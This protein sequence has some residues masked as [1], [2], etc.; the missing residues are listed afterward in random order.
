MSLTVIVISSS[1]THLFG[2]V[3]FWPS[4]IDPGPGNFVP[5]TAETSPFNSAPWM[6]LCSGGHWRLWTKFVSPLNAVNWSTSSCVTRRCTST[7]A[8]ELLQYRWCIVYHPRR[9]NWRIDLDRSIF[10][11]SICCSGSEIQGYEIPQ[12]FICGVAE[13]FDDFHVLLLENWWCRFRWID[14]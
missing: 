6:H 7:D 2:N 9:Q 4:T 13:T 12:R 5:I 10:I 14:L 1:T 11:W 3:N 8:N